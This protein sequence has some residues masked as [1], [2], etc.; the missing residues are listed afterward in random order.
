MRST[1]A[2]CGT[3]YKKSSNG[4]CLQL[5]N[6]DI[7]RSLHWLS[8]PP[9]I[10]ESQSCSNITTIQGIPVCEDLIS[11]D[12]KCLIWS[13]ISTTHC[14]GYGSLEF[15]KY[16]S[17][18]CKVIVF[19]Y[20][21][22]YKRNVCEF[23]AKPDYTNHVKRT[24]RGKGSGE[25]IVSIPG[26]PNI[27]FKRFN[28]WATRMYNGLYEDIGKIPL[29]QKVDIF[30]IQRLD[31]VEEEF[32]GVQYT[33][34]S[35]LFLYKP[36]VVEDIK[37]IVF[38]AGINTNTLIDNI[39]RESENAWSM[40][41]TQQLMKDFAV[42][43]TKAEEAPSLQPL[44]FSYLLEQARVSPQYS[45]YHHSFMKVHAQTDRDRI[46]SEFNAWKPATPEHPITGKPPPYCA[47][48]SPEEDAEM[49][50][51]IRVEM[52]SRCHPTR[53][54]VPCERDRTYDAFIPC[55]EELANT[56]AEDYAVTMKWC[57][58]SKDSA[59]IPQLKRVDPDAAAAFKRAPLDSNGG[60]GGTKV[61]LAFF[62][63]VYA[64]EAFFR[65]L[66]S[67]LYSAEH[68][69]LIHVDPTGASK[70]YKKA[71]KSLAD[72]YNAKI[73]GREYENVFICSDV[74]IVYGASTATI[75]LSK[76]MSWFARETSGWD[77]FI[78]VTG[79]DY[80][81][82]TL[83]HL[84][85]MLGHLTAKD[86][87]RPFVMA[88][89]PGT[90]THLF[91]LSKTVPAFE[92]DPDLVTSINAVT[93]ERGRIL[94]AVPME[95]RST[96]FG[97][98]LFCNG[99]KTFYHLDNRRNK[100]ATMIDTQWLFPRDIQPGRGRAYSDFDP[101][102]ASPSFDNGW[103]IW[104]KS[105][106]A[107]TGIYDKISID[108]IANSI[109]GRKY[110]HFFK[111]M[112]LGSEEHYYVS[113]LYNWPRTQAFVQTLSAQ[114]VWNTWELGEWPERSSGF[115]THT[116]FLSPAEWP[117]IRGF[118][119]RGMIFARKFR[120]GSKLLDM[121][122][123]YVH[124]NSSTDASSFWPGYFEVDTWT[125]GKA[126]VQS[127]RQNQTILAEKRRREKQAELDKK[128]AE[129]RGYRRR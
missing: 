6:E 98:P 101:A 96:N 108:Y 86:A 40:W 87:A 48:P 31:G 47:V 22:P 32:D 41:G 104:K 46:Q 44:Q 79:S 126:W 1:G 50:R 28:I 115:Q 57:D 27:Q 59:Q 53:L 92:F 90:S 91:R 8:S 129:H 106:P 25:G 62:F 21:L 11:P 75:V 15:E 33:I 23:D 100:S 76:A 125:P 38:T 71:I 70:E 99:R 105:D 20:F 37:Q 64:D 107:T 72:E 19:H 49:Q 36:T 117:Q 93:A 73:P 111:H 39:G 78:P 119:K 58:F 2:I 94:G 7:L 54:W 56:L 13:S 120:S 118:S 10:P 102:Y 109:E 35:D 124:F 95:Y 116:H 42:F 16:W 14:N 26:Y 51:W 97:P 74:P 52:K 84:E 18:R 43:S 103:R 89:T 110:F 9:K 60:A 63:T 55:P 4:S 128:N 113:L 83:S 82:I 12:G 112:L 122:D 88:W 67:K 3:N 127:Y 17:S 81:L 30:K 68:Y 34:L 5:E 65:R 66:L 45:F 77:Y 80:P 69:Y 123:S 29:E 121:I 61:R 24:R 114:S 85:K